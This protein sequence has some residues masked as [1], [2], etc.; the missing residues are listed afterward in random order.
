MGDGGTLL[1]WAGTGWMTQSSGTTANL[2]AVF[3]VGGTDVWVV[4][5]GGAILHRST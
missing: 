4:T 2:T 3:G 1:K 5:E